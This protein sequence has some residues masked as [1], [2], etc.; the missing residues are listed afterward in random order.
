MAQAR[1]EESE[2]EPCTVQ[3]LRLLY[4]INVFGGYSERLCLSSCSGSR[5]F[6]A[7]PSDELLAC[8][9][10]CACMIVLAPTEESGIR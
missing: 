1:Y 3:L 5:R 9:R 6:Q 2:P 7:R 4:K 10:D 8:V